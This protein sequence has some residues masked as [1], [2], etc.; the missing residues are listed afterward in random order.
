VASS[1]PQRATPCPSRSADPPG[2][3]TR[4]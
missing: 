1:H 2:W 3:R 4:V